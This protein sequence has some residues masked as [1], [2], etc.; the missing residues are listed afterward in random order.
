VSATPSFGSSLTPTTTAS[1]TTSLAT[2]TPNAQVLPVG[3]ALAL[4][5]D[6]VGALSLATWTAPPNG[7]VATVS[8][9]A[10]FT[11]GSGLHSAP[12]PSNLPVASGRDLGR[13]RS[14]P[15]LAR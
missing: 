8:R 5:L 4:R 15:P 6:S 9:A 14:Q 7:C 3:T 10:T 13:R 11:R 2:S 1:G 12:F